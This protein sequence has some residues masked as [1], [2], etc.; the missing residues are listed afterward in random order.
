MPEWAEVT[1][2][3]LGAH[4]G[5]RDAPLVLWGHAFGGRPGDRMSLAIDGPEGSVVAASRRIEELQ[6]AYYFAEGAYASDEGWPVG[7]Y[8]GRVEI[9]RDGEVL[10]AAE[11]RLRIE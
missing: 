8:L 3:G 10:D 6:A 9:R 4:P 2:G 11:T 7:D 5:G 1:A